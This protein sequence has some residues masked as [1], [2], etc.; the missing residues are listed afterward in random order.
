MPI[1]SPSAPAIS[2][3]FDVHGF[4]FRITGAASSSSVGMLA[5]DFQF[6]Q[7]E[8]DVAGLRIDGPDNPCWRTEKDT[9]DK[10][11]AANLEA[12]GQVLAAVI[13]RLEDSR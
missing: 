5:G 3:G 2:R 11:S 12:V 6:F 1:E 9:L 10:L 13:R 7:S 4:R 8:E